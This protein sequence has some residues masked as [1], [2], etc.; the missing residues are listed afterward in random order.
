MKEDTQLGR[1]VHIYDPST[2]EVKAGRDCS[3]LKA[4]LGHSKMRLSQKGASKM[5]QQ[6]YLPLSLSLRHKTQSVAHTEMKK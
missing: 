1:M 5:A 3:K 6:R 2:E 4:N